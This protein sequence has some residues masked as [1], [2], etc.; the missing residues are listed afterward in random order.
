MTT[1]RNQPHDVKRAAAQA[2]QLI[3]RQTC[4][5][6]AFLRIHPRPMCAAETSANFRRPR[7]TYQDR[8]SSYAVKGRS[9]HPHAA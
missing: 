3:Q 5:G 7:D 4:E 6:C 2:A 9:Q 1:R 8:C